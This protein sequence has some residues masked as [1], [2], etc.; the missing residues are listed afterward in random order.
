VSNDERLD[1]L[2]RCQ[3]LVVASLWEGFGLPALEGM[4]CGT[5]V[6]A[7]RAGALP[8]VVG[9]AALLVNPRQVKEIADAMEWI[10]RDPSLAR[11]LSTAGPAR[12]SLFRWEE[13]ATQ[14]MEILR[15]CA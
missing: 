1:L 15:Q 3:A 8:E 2:N 6:I 10:W 13:T 5:P 4:A 9:E 12:A 7:A 14:V 11:T